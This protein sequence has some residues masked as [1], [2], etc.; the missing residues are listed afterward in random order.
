MGS[1][2]EFQKL[3]HYRNFAQLTPTVQS[4]AMAIGQGKRVHVS[5]DKANDVIHLIGIYLVDKAIQPLKK[6]GPEQ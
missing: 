4:V 3:P 6:L 2:G 5:V 1:H